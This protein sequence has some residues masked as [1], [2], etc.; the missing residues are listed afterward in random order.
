[1]NMLLRF[2]AATRAAQAVGSAAAVL[3]LT[4]CAVLSRPGA[5]AVAELQPTRDYSAVGTVR[6]EQWDDKVRI[7]GEVRGLKPGAEHGFHLHDK[8]D[9]SSG[10]GT[11]AGGHFNPRGSMHGRHNSLA[12]HAGDLVSL[13]ADANGVARFNF[14]TTDV[15][16]TPGPV[17]VVGR[18]VIVHRDPD[19]FK[20]QP[21]G[22][23]GPRMACAVVRAQ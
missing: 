18:A 2:P 4:A 9:C 20:S 5:V 7:S 14:E 8:G 10:D 13:Q 6:F 15:T 19:D 22:N 23:A 21:A 12:H 3:A 17:S 1:M 16:V 11:S